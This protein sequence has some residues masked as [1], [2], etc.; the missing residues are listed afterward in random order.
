M[1]TP[2]NSSFHRGRLPHWQPAGATFFVTMRLFGSIPKH[3]IAQYQ[4]QKEIEIQELNRIFKKE[5]FILADQLHDLEK[6]Y[7][8][9][10]DKEL[11]KSNEP[12][13][14]REKQ[15]AEI[16]KDSIRLN[17]RRINKCK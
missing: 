6:K 7:F 17:E 14:L 2:N 3:I 11:D 16:V 8:G 15:I 12:Y 9:V 10:F 13:W 4:A 1:T 5:P